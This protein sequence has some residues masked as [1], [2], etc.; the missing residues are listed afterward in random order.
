MFTFDHKEEDTER[1]TKRTVNNTSIERRP[2]DDCKKS[3]QVTW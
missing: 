3:L 1:E 2:T